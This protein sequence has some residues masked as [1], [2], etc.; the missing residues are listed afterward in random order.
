MIRRKRLIQCIGYAC[1]GYALNWSVSEFINGAWRKETLKKKPM[2]DAES[3]RHFIRIMK[4][5]HTL[6]YRYISS[7]SV[8]QKFYFPKIDGVAVGLQ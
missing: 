6:A 1:I 2:P 7:K 4:Q 5:V 3:P 8:F